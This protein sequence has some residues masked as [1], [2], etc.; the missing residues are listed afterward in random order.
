ML[1]VCS[2][3]LTHYSTEI[4][5]LSVHYNIGHVLTIRLIPY[6]ILNSIFHV[7]FPWILST[8]NSNGSASQIFSLGMTLNT[9]KSI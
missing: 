3:I 9:L 2:F 7:I 6:F 8:P 4:L 5:E 1:F